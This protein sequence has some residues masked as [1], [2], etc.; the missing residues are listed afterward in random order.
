MQNFIITA[1]KNSSVLVSM[2]LFTLLFS[3][4]TF[5]QWVMNSGDRSG[6]ECIYL[7]PGE[8]LPGSINNPLTTSI[9]NP[10]FSTNSPNIN[11]Q[12][13][14]I[15]AWSKGV[16]APFI[17][18]VASNAPITPHTYH[19]IFITGTI[20]GSSNVV[21]TEIRI[22]ILHNAVPLPNQGSNGGN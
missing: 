7:Q 17:I 15:S 19:S 18:S 6:P 14:P 16:S 22:K 4:N 12:F 13:L 5:A 3:Q 9:V 20:A 2:I 10:T 8:T 21:S 11:F 1:K